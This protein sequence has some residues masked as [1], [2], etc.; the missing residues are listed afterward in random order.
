MIINNK[1]TTNTT[2]KKLFYLGKN[3][4]VSLL[5]SI[6]VITRLST[7]FFKKFIFDSAATP[8]ILKQLIYKVNK[9]GYDIVV[10]YLYWL[11]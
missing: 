10:C 9:E 3:F 1:T 8:N 4:S 2:R 11:K 5:Y 7:N 6:N